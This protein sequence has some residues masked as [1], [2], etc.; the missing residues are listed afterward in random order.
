MPFKSEKQRRYLWATHPE[1]AKEWA[2]KYPRSNKDLPMYA[3]DSDNK[4]RKKAA[5]FDLQALLAGYESKRTNLNT[6]ILSENPAENGKQADSK[7]E[8]IEIPQNSGPVYAG[9]ER[10]EGKIE[11]TIFDG[12]IN[13]D[14]RPENAINSLLQKISVV[15]SPAMVQ[16]ME[17]RKAMAEGRPATPQP[18]NVNLKNYPVASNVTPPPMGMT[19]PP[20]APQ[21]TQ[22]PAQP[23]QQ[24]QTGMNSPSAHPIQAFGPLSMSGNINGN[25]AFGAKN[26][27]DSMKTALHAIEKWAG[28]RL[29]LWDRIRMKRER[30]ET[31]AKPGDKDYPDAKSWKKVT[32]SG[33]KQASGNPILAY[34]ASMDFPVCPD[35]SD[36]EILDDDDGGLS[37]ASAQK[38]IDARLK[39]LAKHEGGQSAPVFVGDKPYIDVNGKRLPITLTQFYDGV[40]MLAPGDTNNV[41]FALPE[42]LQTLALNNTPIYSGRGNKNQIGMLHQ[43]QASTPAWQ[44]AAGKNDEGG[45]NAKGRASYN[46]ATG[47]NLKAPVTESN[48]KGKRAKRQNSFCARMCGMKRHETGSKTKKDPDSRINKSLRKWNCKCSSAMAFGVKAANDDVPS[49]ERVLST[50]LVSAGGGLALGGYP[51][52]YLQDSMTRAGYPEMLSYVAGKAPI[53]LGGALSSGLYNYWRDVQDA[54]AK[55]K[56]STDAP[57]SPWAYL[58]RYAH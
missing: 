54:K 6:S 13:N 5:A 28:K 21:P 18:K 34:L 50:A 12:P 16:E 20:A 31:P 29:G 1:I 22:Q 48:P 55:K 30:G 36:F 24:A 4:K 2:H 23:Q 9:Q 46:R 42:E 14:C 26:S 51:S 39:L 17:R 3:N 11:G 53:A 40:E 58:A 37:K 49:L 47:G 27:P 15:L 38:N 57:T 35:P 43:K 8:K 32:T 7:Q 44:R 45:L 10:E 33:E 19:A 52:K 56:K 41:Q 25:A